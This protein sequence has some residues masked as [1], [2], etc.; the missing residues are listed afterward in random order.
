MDKLAKTNKQFIALI[1]VSTGKQVKFGHSMDA[2]LEII[3]KHIKGRGELLAYYKEQISGRKHNRPILLKAIQEC[4]EENATLIVSTFNR[5]TRDVYFLALLVHSKVDIEICDML[6]INKFNLHIHAAIA[7]QEVTQRSE[8]IKTSLNYAKRFGTKSGNP[9]GSP[10][11]LTS[12]ARSKAPLAKARSYFENEHVL[13]SLRVIVP[14]KKMKPKV[15]YTV[16]LTFLNAHKCKTPTG[17]EYTQGLQV[18]RLW[19]MYEKYRK[20]LEL[21][22]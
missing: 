9:I 8:V 1:R 17:L 18:K 10:Q 15:K 13:N 7:E 20:K 14:I 3:N 2:Q 4:K 11:N 22:F 16:L 19:D 21:T 5:L 6:E 12:K